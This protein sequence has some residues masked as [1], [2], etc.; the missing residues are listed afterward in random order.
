[1]LASG[2]SRHVHIT[3]P[4][5][6]ATGGQTVSNTAVVSTT[7]DGSDQST[8]TITV[9]GASIHILKT[10]DATPVSAGSPIGFVVT[11]SNSGPGTATGV[12]VSDTL[13]SNAGLSWSIDAANSDTGFSISSG[14]LSATFASLAS[15]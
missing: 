11:V 10:A 13:P 3:S 5:T 14:V 4:T 2:E 7:N 15:G 6:G 8:A 12:A 9:Q 1:S